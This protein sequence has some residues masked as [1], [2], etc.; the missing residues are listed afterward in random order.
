MSKYSLVLVLLC[1]T[2]WGTAQ[3]IWSL[4]DC[5]N[6]A[7]EHHPNTAQAAFDMQAAA[8]DYEVE[9]GSRLPSLSASTNLGMQFG[10]TVDPTTNTFNNQQIG[11]NGWGINADWTIFSGGQIKQ[12]IA[13]QKELLESS[14]WQ[15]EEAIFLLKIDVIAAY[16]A[17]LLADAQEEQAKLNVSSLKEQLAT[18]Q[19]QV[20]SGTRSVTDRLELEAQLTQGEQTK[21]QATYQV[22]TQ[23][24]RLKNVLFL[25][26]EQSIQLEKIANPTA[27]ISTMAT[28]QLL[29]NIQTK[30]P[31][32]LVQQANLKAAEYAIQSSKSAF[33]PT[34]GVFAGINTNYSSA[35]NKTYFEQLNQNLGQQVGLF[36]SVPILNQG[37]SRANVQ[38]AELAL[39]RAA[40]TYKQNQQALD[41]ALQQMLQDVQAAK[42]I[43]ESAE[44]NLALQERLLAAKLRQHQ[45]GVASQLEY[46]IVRNQHQVALQRQLIAS[47]D[48]DYKTAV[49]AFYERNGKEE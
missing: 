5:L 19:K 21:V 28:E 12:R 8:L 10:R 14:K 15:S 39:K 17:C 3:K 43:L 44:Q 6:Y 1:S 11:F 45:L 25:A 30:Y 22:A 40:L 46:L 20:Q 7:V 2:F 16:Y 38:R 24:T 23:Y 34:V 35:S 4:K 49:V 48:F 37:R 32:V 36:A 27:A 33:L 42:E 26:A 31:G 29:Q 47:Y 9:K 18:L 41:I 13:Q